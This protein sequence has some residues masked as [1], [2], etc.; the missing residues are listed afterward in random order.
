M[1]VYVGVWC[2]YVLVLS[3]APHKLAQRSM[4]VIL[5]FQRY[6]YGSSILEKEAK[7][8]ILLLWG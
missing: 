4:P 3:P 6:W 8:F 2:V 1:C 7:K 5:A